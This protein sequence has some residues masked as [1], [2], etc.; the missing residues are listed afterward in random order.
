M[1]Y[2]APSHLPHVDVAHWH[3]SATPPHLSLFSTLFS[4]APAHFWLVV[5]CKMINQWPP[6]A[7]MHFILLIFSSF[8]SPPQTIGRGLPPRPPPPPTNAITSPLPLPP[9]LAS[10]LIVGCLDRLVAT[11]GRGPIFLSIFSLGLR[12]C[13]KQ[14]NQQRCRLNRWH[15]PCISP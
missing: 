11:K 5:V 14:G 4:T 1:R 7:T 2:I 6:K 13:P 9:T 15:A 12:L 8:Y 10:G 3:P